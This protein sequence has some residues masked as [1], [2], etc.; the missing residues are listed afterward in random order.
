[1]V[2]SVGQVVIAAMRVETVEICHWMSIES[3]ADSGLG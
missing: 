3:W 1:M 2:K